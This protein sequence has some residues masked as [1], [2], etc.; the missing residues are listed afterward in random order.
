[1]LSVEESGDVIVLW[2]QESLEGKWLRIFIDGAYCGVDQYDSC[3]VEDDL[4]DSVHVVDYSCE[5][6]LESKV[7]CARVAYLVD[8]DR[9]LTLTIFFE[10]KEIR[11]VC[12][13]PDGDC[14][15]EFIDILVT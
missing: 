15:L 9:H 8:P 5:L 11:L 10:T 3:G 12:K 6:P 4:D 7:I 13:T 2:C 14:Y 1:M